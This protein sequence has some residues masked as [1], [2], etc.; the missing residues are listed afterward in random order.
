MLQQQFICWSNSNYFKYCWVVVFIV[1]QTKMDQQ[2]YLSIF[3]LNSDT[4]VIHDIR[5]GLN[6]QLLVRTT[7]LMSE[8]LRSKQTV[9][10]TKF[11]DTVSFRIQTQQ[12]Q[13]M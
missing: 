3:R 13:N 8:A 9:I 4:E 5:R 7:R 11:K 1:Q 2:P 12:L 6:V 10:K